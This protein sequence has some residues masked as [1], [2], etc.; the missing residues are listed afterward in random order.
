MWGLEALDVTSSVLDFGEYEFFFFCSHI[1]ENVHLHFCLPLLSLLNKKKKK[2]EASLLLYWSVT[3]MK[4]PSVQALIPHSQFAGLFRPM[5][6][7]QRS[8]EVN[9][10][11]RLY[12]EC[13]S[14]VHFDGWDLV[15]DGRSECTVSMRGMTALDIRTDQVEKSAGVISCHS[16][17]WCRVCHTIIK[18]I[19]PSSH[20]L[21]SFFLLVWCYVSYVKMPCQWCWM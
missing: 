9:F 10:Y 18:A 3:S 11:N 2:P 21:A 20:S 6:L 19:R 17:E 16:R 7:T 5:P 14:K 4:R 13:V 8:N 12:Y 1:C 15:G